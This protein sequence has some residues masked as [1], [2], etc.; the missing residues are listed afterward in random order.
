[1]AVKKQI[2]LTLTMENSQI[3]TKEV[4]KQFAKSDIT[5]VHGLFNLLI[6][7]ASDLCRAVKCDEFSDC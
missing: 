5:D 4:C 2:T 7:A 6:I 1:M 3:K